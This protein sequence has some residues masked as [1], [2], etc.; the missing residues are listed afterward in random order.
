MRM[1]ITGREYR[2]LVL[3][4]YSY[5]YGTMLASFLCYGAGAETMSNYVIFWLAFLT[6]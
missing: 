5:C 4:E 2:N 1:T 3:S 6:F